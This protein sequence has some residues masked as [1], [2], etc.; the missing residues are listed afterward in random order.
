[1]LTAVPYGLD[2]NKECHSRGTGLPG[3]G[4]HIT[5]AS[6]LALTQDNAA[7]KSAYVSRPG[8]LVIC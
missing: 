8:M 3:R 6:D 5:H 4:G 7:E 2:L 1:M